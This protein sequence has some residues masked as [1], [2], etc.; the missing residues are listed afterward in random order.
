ML[1]PIL[2]FVVICSY[3]GT[4]CPSDQSCSILEVTYKI[5]KNYIFHYRHITYTKQNL[6]QIFVCCH[7]HKSTAV[8]E[9][10][11][12]PLRAEQ[13]KNIGSRVDIE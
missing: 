1:L 10:T 13:G 7:L 9:A 2:D 8:V 12:K 5:C 6:G 3:S 11:Q 4:T